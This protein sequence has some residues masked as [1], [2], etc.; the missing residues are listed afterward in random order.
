VNLAPGDGSWSSV[1]TRTAKTDVTPA[2]PETV[3]EKVDGLEVSTWEYDSAQ[4]A[5]HMGPMAEDFH[6][7]FG[8]GADEECIANVDA[9]G[10]ALAAIQGLSERLD[11]K[12]DRID[13]QAERVDDLESENEALHAENDRLRD[14]LAALE[15][16]VADLEA[17]RT[18]PATTDG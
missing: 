2:D 12:D 15:D 10:V 11:R 1:S 13:A 18:E 14:R 4:D 3:L 6:E 7:A 8:L 16:R 9:D 5:T 17:E